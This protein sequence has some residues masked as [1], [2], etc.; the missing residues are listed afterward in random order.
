[1]RFVL[2]AFWLALCVAPAAAQRAPVIVIPGRPDVPVLVNGIDVSY[3]VIDGEF[4]LDRPGFPKTVIYRPFVVPIPIYSPFPTAAEESYFPRSGR[5]PGYGRLEVNPPANRRLPP[6]APSYYH[7]W[8]SESDPGPATQY[9]P[10][11][12]MPAVVAPSW[13]RRDGHQGSGNGP[14]S[15][16]NSRPNSRPNGGS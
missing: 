13:H 5:R 10:A 14:Q 3:A 2:A 4:G 1:M 15:Q 8:S 7:R 16:E 11:Y 12:G 6:P 9:A